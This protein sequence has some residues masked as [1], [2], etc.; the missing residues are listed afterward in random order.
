MG[1]IGE[2]RGKK[3]YG[4][5]KTIFKRFQWIQRNTIDYFQHPLTKDG[6][7]LSHFRLHLSLNTVKKTYWEES[8]ES[9]CPLMTECAIYTIWLW[10]GQAQL[11]RQN[12]I[13]LNASW[14]LQFLCIILVEGLECHLTPPNILVFL[15]VH[16]QLWV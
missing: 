4:S 14:D 8:E 6:L 3:L 5:I 16:Q 1:S 10:K 2:G 15:I 9:G 7:M 13:L 11:K 12:S